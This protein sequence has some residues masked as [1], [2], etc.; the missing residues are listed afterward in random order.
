MVHGL[1]DRFKVP[2]FRPDSSGSTLEIKQSGETR[3]LA[4][5]QS[6]DGRSQILSSIGSVVKLWDPIIY[7]ST[8]QPEAVYQ[9][10]ASS[11]R[12]AKVKTHDP[13]FC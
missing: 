4:T 2:L 1:R 12:M 9:L 6:P 7:S 5:L 10:G 8:S 3:G 11:G 13:A